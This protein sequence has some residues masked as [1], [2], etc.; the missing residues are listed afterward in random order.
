MLRRPKNLHAILIGLFLG[1]MAP[2]IGAAEDVSEA[3]LLQ[4]K[5]NTMRISRMAA[6][7]GQISKEE[8]AEF[9]NKIKAMNA[10]QFKAYLQS[11]MEKAERQGDVSG[12]QINE[13]Q[14]REMLNKYQG[15][16]APTAKAP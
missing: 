2:L 12:G 1:G 13:K 6:E 9:E 11:E 10:K 16:V 5:E 8:A 14:L 15:V 7:M 4:A 3:Q